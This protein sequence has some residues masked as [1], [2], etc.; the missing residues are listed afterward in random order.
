MT[1]KDEYRLNR[2]DACQLNIVQ[3]CASISPDMLRFLWRIIK[4]LIL[5]TFLLSLL[6]VGVFRFVPPPVT[7][8]MLLRCQEQWCNDEDLRL[9]KE[10]K[11]LEEISPSFPV[12]VMTAEDQKFATHFGFDWEAI[13]KARKYNERHKGI[14]VR[15]AST[16]SQQTAKNVFLWPSR[17][18]IRKGLE[19]YFTFLIEICWSK[20][21]IME[22]YLNVAEMGDGI[23]GV[24]AASR[25]YFRKPASAVSNAE[26]ALVAACLPGPLRW[27]PSRPTNY[28]RKRQGW[29]LR[30]M[31]QVPARLD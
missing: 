23:Y 4:H 7:P 28:I 25:R 20:H 11:P 29:I 6:M 8:L 18:W 13:Q 30:H 14:K 2:P 22:V 31:H 16:I 19:V 26:A 10:W 1:V 5:W 24:E 17:S 15:G 3:F 12:A 9:V 21:R 27:S